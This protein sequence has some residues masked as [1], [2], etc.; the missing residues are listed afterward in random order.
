V[1]SDRD[2]VWRVA[3]GDEAALAQ[4]YDRHADAVY[5]VAFR[6]LG[7]RHLAE[8]VLQETYLALWNRAELYEPERGSLTAWLLTIAR[9]RAVDR[10]RALGRRPLPLPMSA[11]APD[12]RSSAEDALSVG[13]LVASGPASPDPQEEIDAA[14]LRQT[15]RE[16]LGQV[17]DTERRAIEL[18]YYEELTQTEI[19]ARLGWP[20]GTVKTRTRRAL[21]RLRSLLAES[22]GSEAGRRVAPVPMA[23]ESRG[24]GSLGERLGEPV[25]EPVVDPVGEGRGG[26]RGSR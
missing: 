10:L 3:S 22:L 6:L 15:V 21:G 8:E 18:A 20:L 9:N 26:L 7:D 17:P 14:W 24:V 13:R 4:L 11:A 2:L 25:P 5:R 19:A 12:D 1:R 16:A 23:D